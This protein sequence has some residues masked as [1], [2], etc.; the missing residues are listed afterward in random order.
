MK[1]KRFLRDVRYGKLARV[2]TQSE[3]VAVANAGDLALVMAGDAPKLAVFACP[4]GC[5]EIL[6]VNTMPSVGRAWR[7]RV[8]SRG[9]LSLWPSIDL[10]SGCRCHFFVFAN[11]ARVVPP[12]VR[13]FAFQA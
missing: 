4:C 8:D 3:A 7:V 12:R 11:V 13:G 10:A 6:R 2:Q 1:R 5:G 9:R